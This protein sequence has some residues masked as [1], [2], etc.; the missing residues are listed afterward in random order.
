VI[1]GLAK[2]MTAPAWVP[3]KALGWGF[4]ARAV[5]RQGR[6]RIP[7]RVTPAQRVTVRV[8]VRREP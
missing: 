1:R 6:R 7:V 8:V 5:V 4:R 3:V 2:A